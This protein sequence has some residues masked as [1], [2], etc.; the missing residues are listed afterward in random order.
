M[1]RIALRL[2]REDL[3]RI[4]LLSCGFI[5]LIYDALMAITIAFFLIPPRFP[6]DSVL[7]SSHLV[8]SVIWYKEG[9]NKPLLI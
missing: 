2:N 5:G 4:G 3:D 6:S 1:M 7:R 8:Y 9:C